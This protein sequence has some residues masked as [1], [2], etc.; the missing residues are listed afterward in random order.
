[1][2]LGGRQSRKTVIAACVAAVG[3]LVVGIVQLRH[4]IVH[5]LDT[6]TYWSGA[7]AVADGRPFT[8]RLAPSFSNFDA[9]EFVTRDGRLPFVDFPIGYPLVAGL[10][11]IVTGVRAAMTIVVVAALAVV[12]AV[13]VLGDRTDRPTSPIRPILT[14][15]VGVAVTALPASRLVTQGALSEPLF[16]AVVLVLVVALVSYRRG[17]RWWPV[18]AATVAASLLRFIGA[19]LA[20]LAGWEHHRRTGDARRSIAW[21]VLLATPA[22]LNIGLASLAGGG[23]NAGWRGL[24]RVDVDVMVRSIG[25]WLDSRQGDIRRTYFTNEGPSWWSWIVAVAWVAIVV[26][27]IVRLVR[28]RPFLTDR[29]QLALVA[30]GIVTAGLVAGMMGFDALVIPDNRLMLPA[31]VLTLAALCWAVPTGRRATTIAAVAVV[32]W[33]ALAVQPTDLGERFSDSPERRAYSLAAEASGARVVISNDADGVHWDTGLPAAYAPTP[34]KALTREKVDDA[35]LYA[36]LPCALLRHDGAVVLSETVTF[37]SVNVELLERE[38]ERRTL[39][40]TDFDGATMYQ[41]T[42]SACD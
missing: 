25:G 24:Q 7:E 17:G 33:V 20:L 29:S 12:A 18:A 9:V 15:V 41:P 40:R 37:S 19:P 10:L 39:T 34:E 22:A 14:A 32:A 1:M 35:A 23:H 21:T 30:A 8:T 26:L 36:A 5:L 13:V 27:A 4:G 3:A 38:V 11:G 31:G 16:T 2:R 42:E 28:R 6:V